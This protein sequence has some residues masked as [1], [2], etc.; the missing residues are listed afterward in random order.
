MEEIMITAEDKLFGDNLKAVRIAAGKTVAEVSEF[1][2]SKGY[3]AS[4]KTIYSWEIGRTQPSPDVFLTMC[5]FYNVS[6]IMFAFGY[7]TDEN[8]E[9]ANEKQLLSIYRNLNDEGQEKLLGYAD[10]LAGMPKYKKRC[11]LCLDKKE[12]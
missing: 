9:D 10:D 8:H 12:A 4:T 7:S 6:D 11:E 2:I 3:K 1:L 5:I